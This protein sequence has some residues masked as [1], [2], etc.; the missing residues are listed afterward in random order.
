ML[1]YFKKCKNSN[2]KQ[3][4]VKISDQKIAFNAYE[5]PKLNLLHNYPILSN[6]NFQAYNNCPQNQILV[7]YPIRSNQNFQAYN[8]CPQNQI[9]VK[10]F[11]IPRNF[12]NPMRMNFFSSIPEQTN[13]FFM[14]YR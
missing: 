12:Q 1:N 5:F 7:N 14:Y 9:F 4:E 3:E 11:L 8:R 6:Q 2:I 10:T 13:P